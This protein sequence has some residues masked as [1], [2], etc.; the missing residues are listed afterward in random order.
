[1]NLDRL[2]QLQEFLLS[3][4]EDPFL[5]YALAMEFHN[6]SAYSEASK[7]YLYLIEHFPDYIGAYYHFGRLYVETND[8]N[9]A[10]D[11]YKKGI[12][13]AKKSKD[14][15]ALRELMEAFFHAGGDEDDL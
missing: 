15:H 8:L 12:S 1:M 6:G 9:N 7:H 11:I 5:W 2:K 10:L 13:I 14:T 3:D 4:P